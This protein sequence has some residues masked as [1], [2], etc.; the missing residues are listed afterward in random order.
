MFTTH[1]KLS[2]SLTTSKAP[3]AKCFSI[4]L[5]PEAAFLP[6]PES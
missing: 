1:G 4:S 3:I 5:S 2:G 6:V